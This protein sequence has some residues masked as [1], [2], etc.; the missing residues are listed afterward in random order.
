LPCR[1]DDVAATADERHLE[2]LVEVPRTPVAT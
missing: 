1:D 2:L